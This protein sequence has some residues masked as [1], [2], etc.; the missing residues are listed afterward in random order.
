VMRFILGLSPREI[1]ERIGR[2]EDAVHGLQHRGRRALRAE[3]IR[4]QSAPT[5][6]RAAN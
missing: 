2:S 3:L 1:A 4:L 5:A 6:L